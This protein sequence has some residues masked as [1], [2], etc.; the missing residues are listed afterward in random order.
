MSNKT[1]VVNVEHVIKK[2]FEKCKG[3][4]YVNV[5]LGRSKEM[6]GDNNYITI[7]PVID[8]DSDQYHTTQIETS[9]KDIV[10]IIEIVTSC[11]IKSELN[12]NSV[13]LLN[14]NGSA[15]D[16]NNLKSDMKLIIRF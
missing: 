8:G 12:F 4:D 9:I 14:M 5:V 1:R 13:Q 11:L 15:V 6:E 2:G 10:D 16:I 7:L 3:F